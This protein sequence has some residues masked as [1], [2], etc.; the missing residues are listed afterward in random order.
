[1][2]LDYKKKYL[3]YKNKYLEA[4][5]IYG[6]S[7]EDKEGQEAKQGQV[8]RVDPATTA[9]KRAL[10]GLLNNIGR[11]GALKD[12]TFPEEVGDDNFK[13]TLTKIHNKNTDP[14]PGEGY[15]DNL[16]VLLK[17]AHEKGSDLQ[18]QIQ[19]KIEAIK[20]DIAKTFF[21][22][23]FE[24]PGTYHELT[25]SKKAELEK[26]SDGMAPT[27]DAA[28]EDGGNE[29]NVGL[30]AANVDADKRKGKDGE[31]GMGDSSSPDLPGDPTQGV[32]EGIQTVAMKKASTQV[33][34]EVDKLLQD[35]TKASKFADAFKKIKDK[36]ERTEASS[37]LKNLFTD[38]D[39]LKNLLVELLEEP[40]KEI[41]NKT[42]SVK[43]A[44][45]NVESIV[46]TLKAEEKAIEEQ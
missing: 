25:K 7:E 46:K 37:N 3:K 6:G 20:N 17:L 19:P 23:I 22:K 39:I 44:L 13:T 41:E 43:R 4:K 5:K 30:D 27:V 40:G 9:E 24:N 16:A 15:I 14:S 8:D 45:E 42:E 38:C 26:S 34:E 32:M 35:M 10:D 11:I 21:K 2:G 12:V 36:L 28:K 1:M 31:D 18:E 29:G 33:N